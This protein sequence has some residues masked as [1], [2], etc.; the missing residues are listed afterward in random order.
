VTATELRL[1]GDGAIDWACLGRFDSGSVFCQLLD[2]ERGG[3]F[4]FSIHDL[5]ETH[6]Q[7]LPET[8]VL[9]TTL[10]TATGRVRMLDRFAM[11]RDGREHPSASSY[12][13]SN[14]WR[15]ASP[16]Q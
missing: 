16:W 2:A 10:V 11:R 6:R 5:V 13:R 3:T 9:E 8:N 15:D 4:S 1:Y 7:Y 12:G 14:V